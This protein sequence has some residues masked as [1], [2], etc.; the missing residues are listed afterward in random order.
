[1]PERTIPVVRETAEIATRTRTSGTVAVT[2]EVHQTTQPVEADL[3]SE[4]VEVRRVPVGRFVDGP[5]PDRQEGD[6][7]IISVLEEVLVVEKRLRVVE[8]VHLVR[9]RATRH[10]HDQVS[11]RHEDVRIDRPQPSPADR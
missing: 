8:E 7:L 10:V 6:V 11:V 2:K 1:M 4:A 9:R 3:R 5:V